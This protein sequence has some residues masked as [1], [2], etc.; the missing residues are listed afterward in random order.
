MQARIL[1]NDPTTHCL[2][3][4]HQADEQL[5]NKSKNGVQSKI[6]L[7]ESVVQNWLLIG[8]GAVRTVERDWLDLH[9][10]A[11]KSTLKNKPLYIALRD[12]ASALSRPLAP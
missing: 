6:P 5:C 12:L 8:S 4:W 2:Y 3:E 9:S 11:L 10:S 7:I 1:K